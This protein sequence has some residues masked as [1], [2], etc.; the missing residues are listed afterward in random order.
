VS[1]RLLVLVPL[2]IERL[3]IG[4]QPG[5]ET[6]R[7]GMGPERAR[8]AAA[9]ALAHRS[10][11]VA[12]AGLCAGI[13]PALRPGDVL[14]ASEL[15]GEDGTRTPVPGSSLLVAALRRRGLRVHTGPLA[16]AGRILGPAERARRADG[17]RAVDMESAWLAAGAGGRPFA[18]ARVVADPA[19]MH[20]ADPR[21]AVAGLQAL[22]S[23]RRVR[24]A[25]ADWAEAAA[26][27]TILLAGPRFCAGVERAVNSPASEDICYA[28]SNRQQAVRAVALEADLV[29]VVGSETSSN[30][31]RLVEVAQ[32]EGT[33]AHLV[34]DETRIDVAWL[35]GAG[36][37]GITAGASVPEHLVEALIA[38]L[39][40]LGPIGVEE[41]AQTI[42][43]LRFRLPKELA[44]R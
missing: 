34:D 4:E 24:G 35:A 9:R 11:A 37:V 12:V 33:R 42:E 10:D 5:L 39:G 44:R 3:A 20:L 26:P 27:R 30:S 15:L 7:T 23:L 18:V 41:R 22:R 17:A 40:S 19:G 38:A 43:S 36:T 2:R 32:R 14:C 16:S 8:I 21:M 25:L 6:L 31:K 13:D 28:T 29:L 1:S